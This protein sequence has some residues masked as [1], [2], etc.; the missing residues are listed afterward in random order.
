MKNILLTGQLK[1][2][3]AQ[4]NLIAF[5]IEDEHP[6]S[7]ALPVKAVNNIHLK[8]F[9]QQQSQKLYELLLELQEL[10]DENQRLHQYN[11]HMRGRLG[12]KESESRRKKRKVRMAT[13][14]NTKP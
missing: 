12:I 11:N 4:I 5:G 2:I 9:K 7:V 14:K 1:Q 6:N 13:V 8:I 10:T 3:D